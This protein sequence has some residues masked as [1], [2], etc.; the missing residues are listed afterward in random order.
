VVKLGKDLNLEVATSHGLN[1]QNVSEI[2]KIKEISKLNI[3]H[4]IIANS[5]FIGLKEAIIKAK[6][7]HTF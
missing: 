5:I 4:S 7:I 6:S 1:Y 3:D 2:V